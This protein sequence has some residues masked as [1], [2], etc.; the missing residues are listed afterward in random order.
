V[1][2]HIVDVLLNKLREYGS[3]DTVR[4][5]VVGTVAQVSR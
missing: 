2:R 5:W 4:L 1:K 3:N